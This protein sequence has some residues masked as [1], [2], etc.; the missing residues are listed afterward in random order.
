MFALKKNI[1]QRERQ[2][3]RKN[4]TTMF[5][6]VLFVRREG[7]LFFFMCCS[8]KTK[9]SL[10][11]RQMHHINVIAEINNVVLIILLTCANRTYIQYFLQILPFPLFQNFS[12]SSANNKKTGIKKSLHPPSANHHHLMLYINPPVSRCTRK[13]SN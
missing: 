5:K 1:G 12:T 11:R 3:L 7:F 4:K 6:N 9:Y 8:S 2:I 13:N 10:F